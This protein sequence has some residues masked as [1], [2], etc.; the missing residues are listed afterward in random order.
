MSE[1][2]DDDLLVLCY[3][4]VQEAPVTAL[5][6]SESALRKQLELLLAKGYCG[7][8]FAAAVGGAVGARTLAV[9]FDDG[10][11]SVLERAFPLLSEL[12]MPATVFVPTSLVGQPGALSW[13][14]L[15]ELA[16][17]GWEIG[18]HT[19]SH[20]MLTQASEDELANEL[21]ES[22]ESIERELD[23][24]CH[25]LAYPYGEADARVIAAAEAAGYRAA[26]VLSGRLAS[27]SVLAW[28]R[29][30]VGPAD[31]DV[32]FRIKTAPLVRRMR[33]S[34]LGEP[35]NVIVRKLRNGQREHVAA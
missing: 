3:H 12:G 17:A 6:V 26:C 7:S 18:S 35:L 16:R 23:Q 11:R 25:S 14:E 22:R 2:R 34:R 32:V 29:V 5:D 31:G 30:G 13:D 1:R 28:P 8:T 9:T 20:A 4:A 19:V 10:H 21:R 15:R 33:G 24:P 27:S